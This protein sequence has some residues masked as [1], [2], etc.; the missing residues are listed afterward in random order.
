MHFNFAG[1]L[2]KSFAH[3]HLIKFPAI[4]E[5]CLWIILKFCNFCMKRL[6]Y[7]KIIQFS[8]YI[9]I[10]CYFQMKFVTLF[11]DEGRKEISIV[12]I[13]KIIGDCYWCSCIEE[14]M[15]KSL[16]WNLEWHCILSVMSW[17]GFNFFQEIPKNLLSHGLS[18]LFYLKR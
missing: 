4:F 14:C 17:N 2:L 7:L 16:L 10:F 8:K 15:L 11:N 5:D 1:H 6:Q 18:V 9:D 12:R 3:F 13:K